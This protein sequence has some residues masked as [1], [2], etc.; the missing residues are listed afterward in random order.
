MATSASVTCSRPTVKTPKP[1]RL[2]PSLKTWPVGA[3][4]RS[5]L[6]V[7]DAKS[8]SRVRPSGSGKSDA[9]GRRR[10]RRGRW[11][12]RRSRSRRRP[13]NEAASRVNAMRC[14][15]GRSDGATSVGWRPSNGGVERTKECD[16]AE[17]AAL[18]TGGSSGIGLAIAR[19]LGEDGYGVTISARRPDKLE[20]AAE[21]LRC[22]RAR[23]PGGA[24]EHGRR[25]GDRGG[26]SSRT[27]RSSGGSTCW[28]TTPASG[29][30]A[31]STDVITTK[32][33]DMQLDVNLRA[34]RDRHARGSA[35]AAEAGARARQGADHQHGVD[36]GQG[37]GRRGCRL[38]GDE[39]RGDR[40]SARRRRRRSAARGSR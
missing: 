13:R 21:E 2:S 28:S 26:C 23:R 6:G 17:R 39:G 34:Y 18:V 15:N 7:A 29:S 36:R 8:S 33:L 22:G 10:R 11:S 16:L 3:T 27:R 5:S 40:A 1:K 35:A 20:A 19:A 37:R 12:P 25:G 31:R 30:A 24:G 32:H 38:L 14:L 4:T 9:D